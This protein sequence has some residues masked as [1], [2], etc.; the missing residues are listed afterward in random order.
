VADNVLPEGMFFGRQK[1]DDD[2]QKKASDQVKSLPEGQ[3]FA[4]PEKDMPLPSATSDVGMGAASGL[5]RGVAGLP[6]MVGNIRDLAS[7]AALKAPAYIESKITGKPQEEIEQKA[8]QSRAEYEKQKIIPNVLDLAPTSQQTIAAAEKYLPSITPL[9]QYEA[10]TGP[11]R[12]AQGTGEFLPSALL[13]PGGAGA[14]LATGLAGGLG[15]QTAKEVSRQFDTP[16]GYQIGA[17]LLGTILGGGATSAAIA[18]KAAADPAVQKELAQKF[19]GQALRESVQDPAAIQAALAAKKPSVPSGV[20]LTPAQL[21]KSGELENLQQRLVGLAPN[22]PEAIALRQQI[23]ASNAALGRSAVQVKNIVESNIPVTDI[24]SAIGLSGT[25]PQHTASIAARTSFDALEQAKDAA[26]KTAWQNPLLKQTNLYKNKSMDAIQQHLD[27]I[28][29]VDS[30]RINPAIIDRIN[31][32]AQAEGSTIPLMELQNLRSMVGD[33]SRSAYR[34]GES[35]L[36]QINQKLATKISDI[37]NDQQNIQF[38]DKAGAKIAAWNNARQATKDYYD[39]FRP[40]FMEKLVA[41]DASGAP[42][43]A[44]EAFFDKMF[45]GPNSVRNVQQVRQALGPSIDKHI[46]DWVMGDLTVGKQ[47]IKQSDVQKYLADPKIAAVA[48][49]VPGLRARLTNLAQKAGESEQSA[50]IRQVNN[51][52]NDLANRGDPQKIADFLRQNGNTLKGSLTNPNEVE[53]INAVQRT[54]DMMSP[55]K[56]GVSSYSKTLNAI[57]NGKMID[58]VLGN[59]FGFLSDAAM[60]ELLTNLFTSA[61]IGVGAGL[62][63]I[64]RSSLGKATSETIGD[65]LSRLIIGDVKGVTVQQLQKAAADPEVMRLLMSKP[66]PEVAANLHRRLLAM[67]IGVEQVRAVEPKKDQRAGRAS[68][69]RIGSTSIADRLVLAAEKAKKDNSKATE[70]LLQVNDE[71]IAKALEIANRNL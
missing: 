44:P 30:S 19:A 46:S 61:P 11:G 15:G 25:N 33:A 43:I 12:I 24:S 10:K 65:S 18:R 51:K 53:F 13:G 22:S 2:K 57:E 40:D 4:R 8:L 7:L 59:K 63:G 68:G 3:M 31:M 67:G 38:G 42:K 62:S 47:A 16:E 41:T 28:G 27:D 34:S 6:G 60:A 14:K 69:G 35:S 23:V 70:P 49:Q 29:M 71:S 21:L 39:T 58:V 37:L 54:A 17:E 50:I 64:V 26:Q 36:G 48:D 9:T 20:Q 1:E 52:F 45:S 56:A 5:A 66:S 55:A 32:L